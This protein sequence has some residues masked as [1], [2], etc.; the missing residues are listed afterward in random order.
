MHQVTYSS[1]NF[2]KKTKYDLKGKWSIIRWISKVGGTF[3]LFEINEH[4]ISG[5]YNLRASWN[6]SKR[7]KNNPIDKKLSYK[8]KQRYFKIDNLPRHILYDPP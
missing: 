4:K 5:K 6:K 8:N 7:I 1:Q 2:Q 3:G